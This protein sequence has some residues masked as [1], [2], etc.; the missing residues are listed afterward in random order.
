MNIILA[1]AS[2][3]R[4]EILE[5]LGVENMRIIPAVGEENA[6]AET[7]PSRI[8][9]ALALEKAREVAAKAEAGETVIAA[10]TIVWHEDRLYGK[11]RSEAEAVSMLTSLSGNTHAVYTGVAVIRDG[12]ELCQAE[13]TKVRFRSISPEEIAAY[14]ASG[15]PMDKAGAYGAQGRASV[16]VEGIEGDFFNVMGLPVCLLDSMLKKLGLSLI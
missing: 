9:C 6:P 2:P 14:V 15:E 11:P 3:R 4:K 12:E 5:M 13:E 7:E 10:D 1:S 8:V 16:F